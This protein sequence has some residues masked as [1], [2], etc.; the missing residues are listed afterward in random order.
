[1]AKGKGGKPN[2][3]AGPKLR[4]K[5]GPKKKMFHCW[6]STM[7]L[8]LAKAGLLKKYSNKE[9]FE[10]SLNARGVRSDSSELWRD[11][12]NQEDKRAWLKQL[13]A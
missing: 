13:K 6:D 7:R 9:A 2:V 4:K 12:N 8:H 11:F 1:M 10:Q 5:H 3:T